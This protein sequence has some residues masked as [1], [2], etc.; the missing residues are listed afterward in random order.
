MTAG[1]ELLE[2]A[3]ADLAGTMDWYRKCDPCLAGDLL[4][5]VEETLQRIARYPSS[6]ARQEGEF[7]RAFV[8]RYPYRIIYRAQGERIV[9]VAI[10]HTSRHPQTWRHPGH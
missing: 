2:G 3:Q 10:L 9:V 7:R 8:H 6:F 5:C 4:L 1:I